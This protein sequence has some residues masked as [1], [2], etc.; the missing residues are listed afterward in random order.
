MARIHRLLELL[1]ELRARRRPVPAAVLAA[2]LG[3]SLRTLYRDIAVLR[4]QGARIEGEPGLGYVLRP[5]FMLPPLMFTPEEIEVLMLGASWVGRR[6]DLAMQAPARH[7]LAKIAAVLPRDQ[8]DALDAAGLLLA[9]TGQARPTGIDAR[10]VRDAL[11]RE[12]KLAIGYFDAAAAA[13]ERV[14]WPVAIGVYEDTQLLAAWCEW[15]GD[16]RHFR[17]DR[18]RSVRVLETRM[19]R[20]RAMLYQAWRERERGCIPDDP[21]ER[22]AA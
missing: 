3:V 2:T 13:S 9:A 1:Q 17:L 4:A 18:I 20:R 16:F 10:L 8:A 7:A 11:R 22:D 5:G 12:R 14:I 6:Q 15:R 21:R 19:P